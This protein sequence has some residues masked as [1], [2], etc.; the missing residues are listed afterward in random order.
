MSLEKVGKTPIVSISDAIGKPQSETYAALEYE[1]P[2]GSHKD[3]PAA[4]I[5]NNAIQRGELNPGMTVVE[6]T[7][8]SM[9]I[10]IAH[11]CRDQYKTVICMPEGI[12]TEREDIIRSLGAELILTP[13]DHIL[14]KEEKGQGVTLRDIWLAGTRQAAEKIKAGSPKN[15]FLVNQSDNFENLDAFH[16]LGYELI[17]QHPNLDYFVCCVGTGATI[18]GVGEVLRR[19]SPR[20]KIV[21]ID[22]AASP[23]THHAFY[24]KPFNPEK[25]HRP[26]RI[27]GIG[28]GK[29]SMIA[30]SLVGDIMKTYKGDRI[31]LIED[32]EV[33]AM[34]RQL[35]QKGFFVGPTS[36]AN[37]LVAKRILIRHPDAKIGTVFFD[38]GDRYKSCGIFDE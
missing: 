10:S 1:N 16:E 12:S 28:A 3:R 26:H 33:H 25:D 38:K 23:S 35:K 37:A 15:T 19:Y 2:G 9:G 24:K 32:G 14:T 27:P 30:E 17:D 36:G 4:F 13:A 11:L 5:L 22:A 29:L 6:Y 20:T 21:G 8:G 7:S 31:E 18:A 34:C